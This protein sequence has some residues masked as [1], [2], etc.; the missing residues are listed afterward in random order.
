MISMKRI[1]PSH[2]ALIGLATFFFGTTPAFAVLTLGTAQSYAV[3][4]GSTVTNTGPSPITGDLGVA[5]GS[6]VTG[7]PPGTVSGGTIHAADA[8]ATQAQIDVTSAYTA[9]ASASGCVDKSGQDL[10]GQTLTAGVYCFNTS[11]TLTGNLSLDFGGNPNA[12]FIFKTG[13][14]LTTA[15]GSQVFLTNRGNG[16]STFCP[17]NVYWQVGSSATLGTNSGFAGNILAL[18]SITLTTG[19]G[20]TGRALARNGAVTLDTNTVGCV[21]TTP[22]SLLNFGVE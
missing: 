7:F 3:L 17:Q 1:L 15:S 13:T 21:S 14:T 6:S 10:G 4:G 11:A 9:A 18:T 19:A 12:Q 16:G 22:V 8:S 20:L 5:P 2:V